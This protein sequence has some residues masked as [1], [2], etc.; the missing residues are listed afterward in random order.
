MRPCK[1][2]L[3]AFGPFATSETIDFTKLPPDALFLIHGPT[4]AGKTSILDGICYAL[5][6]VTSGD[7][8]TGKQMRSQHAPENLSTEIELEFKLGSRLLRIRRTPDQERLSLRAT[9]SGRDTVDIASTAELSEFQNNEW[10]PLANK[11]TE[12]T[13]KIV[14]LIGFQ[15]EQ[16][17]QVIMLPQGK[18]R[19]FLS[20]NSKAREIILEA[21]FSTEIYKQ[22]QDRLRESARSLE[23]QAKEI[24]LQKSE[25]L[26]QVAAENE[27]V[28]ANRIQDS[29]EKILI[30]DNQAKIIKTQE[31]SISNALKAEE[32]LLA[33]FNE[34]RE[35]E[36][37][38]NLILGEETKVR[39]SRLIY[40][41]AVKA[42]HI[43]PFLKNA[44][45]NKQQFD[46]H[47]KELSA[48]KESYDKALITNKL[49]IDT[50]KIEDGK[51][52]ERDL[53]Q[54]QVTK[55]EELRD[56]VKRFNEAESKLNNSK[57]DSAKAKQNYEQAQLLLNSAKQ[58]RNSIEKNIQALAQSASQLES[59]H[60]RNENLQKINKVLSEL[61][62]AKTEF[63]QFE[64][65]VKSAE[66]K[67]KEAENS[68]LVALKSKET[69]EEAWRNGQ[70]FVLAQH[71][72]DDSPCPVC[73]SQDHPHPAL[74]EISV[75]NDS[76]LEV[77]TNLIKIAKQNVDA[78]RTEFDRFEKQLIAKKTEIQIGEK[79][80]SEYE[81]DEVLNINEKISV[82]NEALKAAEIAKSKHS[83]A[84]AKLN[85]HEQHVRILETTLES[86]RVASEDAG[87][88]EASA[89]SIYKERKENTPDE[90]RSPEVLE[91]AINEA[92][93]LSEKLIAQFMNARNQ[94]S[95]SDR[96][97]SSTNATMKS[98]IDNVARTKT[99][100]ESA[101]K[102]LNTELELAGISDESS[103]MKVLLSTDELKNLNESIK[104]HEQLLASAKDRFNRANNNVKDK[105]M[106]DI[107]TTR[108]TLSNLRAQSDNN[109]KERESKAKLLEGD[110]RADGSLKANKIRLDEIEN[111]FSSLGN[112]SDIANGKNGRNLTFQ[113]YVLSALL[114]QVLHQ[115]SYR[116]RAMSHGRYTLHRHENVEDG[117]KASG[118]DLDVFDEFTGKARPATTLSGGEGF[119]AALSLALGLS[120]V[121]QSY[122]GG[123][124][125]DT[126]FIDEGFGS[127]DSEALDTA[128]KTL[129]D[130][131]QSGRMVGIISHVDELKRQIDLGI[132]VESSSNGSHIKIF[133]G[134]VLH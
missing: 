113:R 55:L 45:S 22:L 34:Y 17:R 120:D 59:L 123:I 90:Y 77:A 124:Q 61:S 74:D 128:L 86:N 97:L 53:T 93:I 32:A 13:A 108:S 134:S 70:A 89:F 26:N 68:Y 43:I 69:L 76:D 57:I 46:D 20:A 36:A 73:G 8:R 131:Q 5:Y 30:L 7:E 42:N 110:Q 80:L 132:E 103:L 41:M 105:I 31:D 72:S 56:S 117:R 92:K 19:D 107:E 133:G 101:Y 121:V 102:A 9:K 83:E 24:S 29:H 85:A 71:L 78:S 115:A 12:V 81:S 44:K 125:L 82:N 33:I 49:A 18:F 15:A 100:Y 58:E 119:I 84:L 127:L 48:H 99:L 75:P 67:F 47:N 109:I 28:L 54:Q 51:Q 66:G 79:A 104:L 35:A 10:V 94:A 126:L 2:T 27:E 3:T 122:A 39:E 21:L 112:L 63:N 6:G 64:L 25:I 118:L 1:L 116:L 50:L 114:D 96:Q 95:E 106:P 65:K 37:S 129:I 14:E 4:G 60:F 11:T 88:K 111:Q 91:S 98:A 87:Q 23:L 40:D 130:L 38:L 16:F 62:A 52:S